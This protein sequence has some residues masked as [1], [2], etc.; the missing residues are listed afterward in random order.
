MSNNIKEIKNNYFSDLEK[1][2][3]AWKNRNSDSL[4]AETEEI[5]DLNEATDSSKENKKEKLFSLYDKYKNE[6]LS[7]KERQKV[8][9][10]INL[11]RDELKTELQNDMTEYK[12][13]IERLK[14]DSSNSIMSS[15]IDSNR[16]NYEK[17]NELLNSTFSFVDFNNP[18]TA[19]QL[20]G[21]TSKEEYLSLVMPWYQYYCEKYGIKYPG[22]LALQ[23]LH[24][25]VGLRDGHIELLSA[26]GYSDNNM[27]GLKYSAR[28][29][30]A[31]PGTPAPANE[32][33]VP[34][35]HFNSISDY[36]EAQV[37]NI[38]EG[39]YYHDALD[40]NSMED[41][42]TTLIRIWVG[43]GGPGYSAAVIGEY[44]DYGLAD[45][46]NRN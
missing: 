34:Y 9:E 35:C 19:E 4:S 24:E 28:I 21:C 17:I 25:T 22:V 13:E 45:Y 46:E 42:A 37:W 10:E 8:V 36:I 20:T 2:K 31:T 12:N 3:E 33:S 1:S 15:I 30:N 5:Y 16:Q 40:A 23:S 43:N 38:A 32:G 41:F 7:T 6:D 14:T 26:C 18:V 39:D 44:N 29:P 11:L 27:G